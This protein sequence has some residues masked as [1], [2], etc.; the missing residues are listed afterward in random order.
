MRRRFKKKPLISFGIKAFLFMYI[1]SISQT[2]PQT[3]QLVDYIKPVIGTQGEGNVYP[4][5]VVPHGMVQ[6]GP[7]TDKKDWGT[8]SG[9]EYSDSVIIGFS[10]QHLSGTGIPDLGDF[11]MMPSVGKP[12]FNS[13]TVGKT[14]PEGWVKYYQDPDSGYSTKFSH[15][16]EVIKPGYYSVLL[17]EHNVLVELAATE[18]AG[19][20]KF[21]FPKS[22]SS[23]IM[24][25]LSHVLQ[26]KVVFSSLRM[27]NKSLVT[28]SHLVR[29]WAKERYL[30]FAARYSR[31]YDDFAI[32]SNGRRVYY[33]TTRFTSKYEASSANLQYYTRYST[34]DKEVIMVK[35]G[36]SA[37]STAA[38]LMNLDAEIPGWDFDKVVNDARAK[39]NKEM[40]KMVIVGTQEEKETFYTSLYHCL[41]T[42]TIYEDV[43]GNYRGF[44]QNIHESKNFTNY[45]IFSLWDTYRATHPLFALIQPD[46]DADMINSMLAHYDQS[47]DHLLPVW[48][49]N[50]NETWC[51]IGYHAVPVIADAMMQGV[52]GFDY[53]RAYEACKTTAMNPDYDSVE[54]YA[55][56][57]YVPF[58]HENESV[59]KTL[60]YAY[61]DY[62]IAQMAKKLG[63]K[64]DYNYFLKRAMA[65]VN[66]FDPST[67]LMRGK[68]SKGN[69]RTPFEPFGYIDDMDKRDI[70]EGTNWQYSWY[71]PHDVQGLINLQGGPEAFDKKLDTLFMDRNSG[72]IAKGSEDIWGR[73]GEYWHGNEPAHHVA[74]LYNYAGKPWKTQELVHNIMRSQYGNKPNSLCGNDDC[75]QMSAWYLF[76]TMGFYPVAP[77]SNMY[78]IGTPCAEKVSMKLGNGKTFTT[79]TVNYSPKNMYIQ[80]V[81]LNGKEYNKTYL[82]FEDISKGGEIV[83]TMGSQPNMKWGT[84]KDSIP[85]SISAAK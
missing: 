6:L 20:L 33:N 10:M 83:Y 85:P 51:M 24:M 16:D 9:Y 43:N 71:V 46:R 27:E 84:S 31:P 41:L 34:K 78:V 12:E 55:R 74:Y 59:S 72:E 13:G 29:G 32:M 38:A 23:N 77:A 17:P 8:A 39:W 28:G 52:K 54:E 26:W 22:D 42:P 57:G 18:R 63:K 66:I 67:K 4:G 68:D 2:F 1:L 7:D 30:Y 19:I 44:D 36:I 53:E 50:N 49:L 14:M 11:L 79:K 58:D 48:S 62:C 37:T 56:I 81:K 70:T 80:S 61:D 21:T 75:G 69:W 73:F 15:S 47:V 25:D 65:Y 35:I 76:N 82:T 60:E 64:D 40:Q 5:P 3:E 45:A